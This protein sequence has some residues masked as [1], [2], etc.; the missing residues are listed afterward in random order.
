MDRQIG[1]FLDRLEQLGLSDNTLVIFS[2][3][4]GPEDFQIG[5]AAPSG[6]GS[7]GP[8]RGRKRSIYEGGIRVPF[9]LRWPGRVA[10]NTV[11]T[12]SVVNGVDFMPTLCRLAGIDLPSSIQPDGE[13]MMDVWLG[14]T[15]VRRRPCFWEWRYRVFGH[16]LNQPPRLAI[17][18]GNYKLLMNPERQRVELYN[19]LEDPSELQNLAPALPKLVNRLSHK[20]LEWNTSLPKSPVE[21]VAGT[22]HWDWP[23]K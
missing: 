18:D 19:I 5:N 20:L 11:N 2:R 7:T 22:N 8:F 21:A 13:D 16:I 9:I 6:I 15:R 12:T 23:G 4:N 3:D 17:R 14:A 10:A 1:L